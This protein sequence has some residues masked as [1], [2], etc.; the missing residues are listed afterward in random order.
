MPLTAAEVRATKFSTTRVRA[1]YD[2][3]EVDAFLDIV[4]ADVS[5][6]ADELQRSRDG[7][8]V[9][10]TTCDQMQARLTMAEERLADAQARLA[11]TV[12]VQGSQQSVPEAAPAVSPEVAALLASDPEAQSVLALAQ[13]TADEIVRY[14]QIRADG[15][16]ADVRAMLSEQIGLVD[17]R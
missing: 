16:R 14:A 13:T 1:G 7:E 10:R 17:R 4:E 12:A 5:Q 9:L 6:Y 8:A 11:A 3:D 15:I 2:M